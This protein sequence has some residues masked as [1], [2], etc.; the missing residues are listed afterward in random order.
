MASL[1]VVSGEHAVRVFQR[2]GWTMARQTSSHIIMTKE[3]EIASL[4]ILFGPNCSTVFD[5]VVRPKFYKALQEY[6]CANL[7]RSWQKD[8][9]ISEAIDKLL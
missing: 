7:P 4:S 6:G 8:N 9:K 3:G 1:P 5:E 2:F